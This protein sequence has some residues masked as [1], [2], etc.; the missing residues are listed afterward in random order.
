MA[1]LKSSEK[2]VRRTR[3][4]TERNKARATRLW[5][6][7]RDVRTASSRDEALAALKRASELLDRAVHKRLIHRRS[8]ARRKSRLAAL[9]SRK[10]A[11]VKTA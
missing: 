8:A 6:A 5:T 10:F 1:N 11:A 9:V 4:R 3:R 2:D 7:I